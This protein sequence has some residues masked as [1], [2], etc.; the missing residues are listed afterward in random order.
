MQVKGPATAA[1]KMDVNQAK[2]EHLLA[3]KGRAGVYLSDSSTERAA[4]CPN[5]AVCLCS[6]INI[7]DMHVIAVN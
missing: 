5:G 7:A 6:F 4:E 2:Q 1:D 3:L